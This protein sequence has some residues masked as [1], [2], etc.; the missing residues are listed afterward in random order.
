LTVRFGYL[1]RTVKN[2]LLF[3]PSISA[4]NTGA[5]FL[6]SRGRSRYD[7]FQ[8]VTTY[9]KPNFG[10][11]NAS[12]VF[13]RARG[14]LNMADKIYGDAPAFVLGQFYNSLGTAIKAKFD[15]EF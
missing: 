13:S 14:D 6:S 5:I 2:D 7:E 10:Q 11:W 12:Y 8:F 1:K 15:I 9:N 4:G 3:E